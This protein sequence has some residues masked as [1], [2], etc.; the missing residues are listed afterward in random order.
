MAWKVT[1]SEI[2]GV[3]GGEPQVTIIMD[4]ADD[5]ED[6]PTGYAPGSIAICTGTGLPVYMLGVDGAW[7]TA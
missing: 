4:S 3:H 1:N 2:K 7:H 6:L 5:V